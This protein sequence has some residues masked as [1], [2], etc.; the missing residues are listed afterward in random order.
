MPQEAERHVQHL[1]EIS[2]QVSAMN[3]EMNRYERIEAYIRN[4]M[5]DEERSVFEKELT[6]DEALRK[7]YEGSTLLAR[8]IRKANQEADLRI[9]LEEAERSL[10]G[11][12]IDESAL[13]SE[14]AQVEREL[15]EIHQDKRD[16]QTKPV[17]AQKAPA[18]WFIR[19]TSKTNMGES[20]T[21][22]ATSS[23]VRRFAV[24]FAACATLAL[25]I[26]LPYNALKATAGYN[27]APN[28]LVQETFRGDSL[29]DAIDAY[30]A[31]DY[32][33][34]LASL[35]AAKE[36]TEAILSRLGDSDTDLMVKAGQQAKLYDIDWYRALTLMKCKQVKEAKQTLRTIAESDS[37]HADEAAEILEN[38]Y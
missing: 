12:E 25:V 19:I 10:D 18:Q 22:V 38:V 23:R 24:A 28:E 15:M 34:A 1:D 17:Q 9:S 26:I 8:A 31:G 14:L 30:N 21:P 13:E 37:P 35:D 5:T 11:T 27:Y 2:K 20:R 16:S 4:R 7:E 33:A 3:T 36:R 29:S 6:S 32:D